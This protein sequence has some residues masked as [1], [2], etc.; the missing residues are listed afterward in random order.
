MVCTLPT[1]VCRPA[2][3]LRQHMNTSE[4]VTDRRLG[5]VGFQWQDVENHPVRLILEQIFWQSYTSRTQLTP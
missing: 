1:Q 2:K 3:H 4:A 5:A